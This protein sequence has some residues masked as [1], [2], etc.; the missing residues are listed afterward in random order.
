VIVLDTSAVLALED[1][2]DSQHGRALGAIRAPGPLVL[3]AGILAEVDYMVTRRIHPAA[4]T[5][6]L[7]SLEE[8]S[9][10]L[11]CGDLDLARV[12]ELIERY[13]DLPLGFADAAVMACA[14]RLDADVLTFDRRDFDVVA[15]EGSFRIVP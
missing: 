10:V 15:G 13:A 4:M 1:R 5:P 9:L 6:V 12:R 11:D 8:G 3:P 2:N 7:E 14:E